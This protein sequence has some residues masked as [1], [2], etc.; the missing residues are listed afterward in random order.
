MFLWAQVK[1][2]GFFFH[3]YFFNFYAY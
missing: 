1:M 2:L 3:F